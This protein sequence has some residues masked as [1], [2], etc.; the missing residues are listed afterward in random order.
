[1]KKHLLAAAAI[2]AIVLSSGA[3]AFALDIADVKALV[4]NNVDED[5]IVSMMLESGSLSATERDVSEL[6]SLGASETL[7]AAIGA[8]SPEAAASSAPGEYILQDGTTATIPQPDV[9]YYEAP[10]V[11]PQPPTVYY[12]APTYVYPYRHFHPAP[13]FH[14]SRP[15]FSITFGFGSGGRRFGRRGFRHW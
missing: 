5:V 2:A 9:V 1:M 15:G 3:A 10:T 14:R 8:V 6:R 13:H 4:R 11:V 7:V 12:A